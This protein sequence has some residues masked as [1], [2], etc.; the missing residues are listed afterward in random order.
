MEECGYEWIEEPV[1]HCHVSAL[2]EV[3]E[4][5]DIADVN[6]AT[7]KFENGA[8]GSIVNSCALQPGQG[9]PPNLAGAIHI[10]AKNVTAMVSAGKAKASS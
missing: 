5:L 2:R 1:Q 7:L 9:T 8:V 3:V 6:S 10:L 4:N